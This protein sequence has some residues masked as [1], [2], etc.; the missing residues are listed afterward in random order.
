MQ[1]P[2]DIAQK[3]MVV[4]DEPDLSRLLQ[5]HLKREGFVPVLAASGTEALAKIKGVS[6]V[7]LDWMMPGLDGLEVLRQLR[8]KEETATLPVILLTARDEESD[9]IVGL[10]LGADDYVTKPFS[11][12]ELMARIKARLRRV[13]PIE[14]ETVYIYQNLTMNLESHEVSVSGKK[15]VLTAKE[16]SLLR[17]LLKNKGKAL[18]RDVLLNAIWGYDYFGTTR[19]VDVHIRRLREKIPLLVKGLETVPSYGYKVIDAS[20][21]P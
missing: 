9:K 6:L 4:D 13:E 11:V 5:H 17:F 15:V 10:E 12:K 2:S 20:E 3:I 19:T 16:F 18:T 7:V 8:A 14:K 21:I 1:V